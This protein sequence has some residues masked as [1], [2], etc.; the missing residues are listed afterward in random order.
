MKHILTFIILLA[1]T[2]LFAQKDT[3]QYYNKTLSKNNFSIE[4]GGKAFLYSIGYERTIYKSKKVLVTG[5]VN[6][7]YEPFLGFHGII[8]PIGINTLIGEKKNKLVLAFYT[9]NSFDFN[10]NP[11]TS[12]EREIYR[13]DGK[14][15]NDKN[16]HPPYRLYFIIP[17]IGYR[18]YLKNGNSISFE[19][20]QPFY[21]FYGKL[22]FVKPELLTVFC[23]RYNIIFKK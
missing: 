22:L 7:S 9:T 16:Y 13:A 23:F 14:Y 4:L 2:A 5:S 17:S 20:M 19:Y 8:T 6:L 3:T 10:P 18:R 15:K 1:Y 11:K 12:E 21:N